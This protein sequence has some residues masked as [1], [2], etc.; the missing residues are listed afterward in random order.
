VSEV[1]VWAGW[2]LLFA[3]PLL[4]TLTGV[5]ALTLKRAARLE[6]AA[7]AARF[8]QEWREDAGRTP[9]WIGIVGLS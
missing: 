5:F 3:D 1:V 2:I 8:G 7:L 6:D 9:R 4:A